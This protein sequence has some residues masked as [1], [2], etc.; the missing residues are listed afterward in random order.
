[1]N[2]FRIRTTRLMTFRTEEVSILKSAA[3]ISSAI[4]WDRS[5]A[6]EW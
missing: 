1:M 6:A 5:S 2:I 4:Q 3:R